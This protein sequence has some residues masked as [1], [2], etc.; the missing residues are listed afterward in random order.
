MGRLAKKYEQSKQ[1][2]DVAAAIAPLP[3]RQSNPRA[4]A[5]MFGEELDSARRELEEAQAQLEQARAEQRLQRLDPA[6]V[7]PS[8][9]RN[10]DERS[11]ERPEFREL[12]DSIRAAGGNSVPVNVRRVDDDPDYDYE[13]V[14]GLRRHRACLEAGLPL[15][16]IVHREDELQDKAVYQAMTRE[17]SQRDDLTPWEWGQHYAR[18]LGQYYSTQKELADDNGRSEAHVSLA[19]DL[20]S[21]PEEIVAAFPSPLDLQLKWGRELR[22]HLKRAPKS[23]L[24]QASDLAD[25]RDS[26]TATEVFVELRRAAQPPSKRRSGET[27]GRAQVRGKHVTARLIVETRKTSIE[28]PKKLSEGQQQRLSRLIV[29]FLDTEFTG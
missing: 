29:D 18:G 27:A 28:I 12:V 14:Y 17:N 23:V 24:A 5:L 22:H 11:F 16:A 4:S 21:L 2:L 20:A 3:I 8:Q 13:I 10:R 9:F 7:R 25:R 19:L 15:L 6:R 26:L 1:Q